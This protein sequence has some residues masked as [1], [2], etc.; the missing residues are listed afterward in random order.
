MV[1]GLRCCV[2]EHWTDG[3]FVVLKIDLHN[4][5]NLVSR[6][7]I[8]DE[9]AVCFPELLP[10]AAWCYGQHPILWHAMGSINSETGV[11]QGD[12]L[13]P[14]F[15][16]LVLQTVVSAISAGD[17]CA[18]LLFHAWYMDDV[19]VA[20][21]RCAINRVLSIIQDQGPTLGLFINT[22][23]CEIF[24]PNDIS[25]FPSAIKRSSVPNMEIS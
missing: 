24:S 13:G 8:L 18:E 2:E 10:W 25:Q 6:Q 19:I 1:H 17:R 4:A 12:P 14:L 23:K 20:S 15:F 3:D 22:A 16:C 9:C 21:P 7:A 11:Q 5:F